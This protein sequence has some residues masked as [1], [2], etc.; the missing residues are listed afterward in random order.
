[1]AHPVPPQITIQLCPHKAN[2]RACPT[3]YRNK[4]AEAKPAVPTVTPGIAQGYVMPIGEAT[5]RATQGRAVAAPVH[6]AP[7]KEFKAPH[8]TSRG[9][10]TAEAHSKDELWKPEKH[11]DIIDRLPRHPH[12]NEG[13]PQVLK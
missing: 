2:P 6:A 3:C 5:Q 7:G 10:A 8:S 12:A 4:P 11:G 13:K 1:M 9:T